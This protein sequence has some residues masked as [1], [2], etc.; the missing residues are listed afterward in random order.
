MNSLYSHR[1]DS[2]HF[3]YWSFERTPLNWL[4]QWFQQ[5]ARVIAFLDTYRHLYP[6]SR[7]IQRGAAEPF[8][9]WVKER[10]A[11]RN[12]P[13]VEAPKSRCLLR[14]VRQEARNGAEAR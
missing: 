12:T 1:K 2:I 3:N 14:R 9:V 6:V 5:P 13:L 4:V 8:Q 10:A 11:G 7:D